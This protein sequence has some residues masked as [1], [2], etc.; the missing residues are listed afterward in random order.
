MY[1][2]PQTLCA[3]VT[4][5]TEERLV[6]HMNTELECFYFVHVVISV[7]HLSML[8]SF[9]GMLTEIDDADYVLKLEMNNG[10]M[11]VTSHSLQLITCFFFQE[12][13]KKQL[14]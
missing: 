9:D 2:F 12:I 6:F 10:L 13:K 4:F 14:L 7:S 3:S 11:F 1:D 8:R 5:F